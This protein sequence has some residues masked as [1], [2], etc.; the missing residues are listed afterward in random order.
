MADLA[1]SGALNTSNQYIKYTITVTQN[2]QSVE[3]NTSNVTVSVRFYRTNTG[4]TT[5]GTGKVYCRI[6]GTL[7]SADVTSS[8]KITSSGIVLFTKTLNVGH[9]DNGSKTLSVSAWISHDAPLTSNEQSYNQVLTTIPRA[10]Q[11]SCI[12]WPNHTQNVGEFGDT[13]SIH[14]N[15]KSSEFKHVLYYSYGKRSWVHIAS[16]ID[17]GTTWTIPE[18]LMNDIP[19]STSGSGTLWLET[20]QN[21]KY[22]GAKSCGFTATVPAEVKPTCGVQVLDDTDT[23]DKYGNLVQGL[24]K[25]KVNIQTRTS[26]SSK[27]VSAST[28]VNNG[29][30]T[31]YSGLSF[32]TGALSKSGEVKVSA[33]VADERGRRSDVASATFTV[34]AYQKPYISSLVVHRCA[35]DGTEDENGEFVEVKFS[36]SITAL[37]NKNSAN[38][39]IAYTNNTT[40]VTTEE[41]LT[42]IAGSYAVTDYTYIFPADS[43]SSYSVKVTAQDDTSSITASTA[44]STAFT[45]Y[46][47]HASGTGWAFGKVSEKERT[48][49]NVLALCQTGNMYAY[50][51]PSFEGATGYSAM[52]VIKLTD[53]NADAPITFVLNRR[54]G[55]SPMTVHVKYKHSSTTV[56]A[57]LDTFTYE[58]DNYGAFLV[59]TGTATWKLYVDNTDGWTNP[60]VQ[61][62]Y[63]TENQYGRMAVTFPSEQV[64]TLPT[65]WYRAVPVIPRS[66]L[67]AFF[68]VGS[69]V[70]R[71]D[72]EDPNVM[73]AG[74]T[75]V[76]IA[77]RFLWGCDADGDIGT[78][79]GEKT[80]TLT[81]NEMPSHHHGSTYSGSAGVVGETYKYAWYLDSGNKMAYGTIS[82]GGGAAHNN[83]PPYIQVSIWRR[84]A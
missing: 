67:D 71:Y 3:N 33:T 44:V 58:G 34:L 37:N 29:G 54:K 57:E 13:I 84:T 26:Y 6:N 46:N 40:G 48:V 8:Q 24:S 50:Q 14:T 66:I 72:H 59:K 51:S 63:T 62:W 22:I 64:S 10:S 60:C 32:V 56:D 38:Y 36:A 15:R 9:N 28:T 65:P 55:I 21:G 35:E 20:Y 70:F 30:A 11:P 77:N 76:R 73:Y 47:C 2:S 61:N 16:N 53:T 1:T 81:V 25:L 69:I 12:T 74:T 80:H 4:Y 68:P 39:S 7:Y 41:K 27:I 79:G 78:I 83:M 52:A 42:G 5:Y 43:D 18:D 17:N 75:W 82:A 31:Q 19:S 49:E 45:L 23:K